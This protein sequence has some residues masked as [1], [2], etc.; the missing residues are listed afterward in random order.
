MPSVE[1][2][3]LIIQR[4]YFTKSKTNLPNGFKKLEWSL[5]SKV[6]ASQLLPFV[7]MGCF[8]RLHLSSLSMMF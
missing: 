7:N 2:D 4:L 8:Q 5:L 6:T 1:G 3:S